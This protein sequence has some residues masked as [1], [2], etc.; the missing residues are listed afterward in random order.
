M[1]ESRRRFDESLF[2]RGEKRINECLT[3]VTEEFGRY[4]PMHSFIEKMTKNL[5]RNNAFGFDC[6]TIYFKSLLTMGI[7]IEAQRRA[8]ED[9]KKQVM[10]ELREREVKLQEREAKIVKIEACHEILNEKLVH[11]T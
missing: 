11:K 4:S 5:D 6:D 8:I 1:S 7:S 3:L 2:R 9:E 10:Q